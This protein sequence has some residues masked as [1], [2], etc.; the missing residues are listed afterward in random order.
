MS[1]PHH[2]RDQ[3]RRWDAWADIYDTEHA[4]LDPTAAVEHLAQ[5]AAGRPALELGVGTGRIALPLAARGVPVTG[6]DVSPR[7]LER[8][9]AKRGT[10]PVRP[11]AGDMASFELGQRFAVVYSA[12]S[13]LFGLPDQDAQLGCFIS[14]A[15]AL[16]PDGRFVV[17]AFMPSARGLLQHRQQLAIR[18]VDDDAL[19]LSATVNDPA[20]QTII[21]QEVRVATEGIRLLPV[22]VRYAWPAEIDLMARLA[23]L[24]LAARW[25]DWD[26]RSFTAESV[27]HVSAYE[28]G[29]DS[30][31]RH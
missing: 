23:G 20:L 1:G 16:E 12:F 5:L 31:R 9:E 27:G 26:A 13:S 19:T 17:E 29:S 11:V 21:F 30:V 4:E 28:L 3:A 15:A 10:L 24:R 25:G 7:M 6:L 22:H 18:A 2:L 8:L 14:T